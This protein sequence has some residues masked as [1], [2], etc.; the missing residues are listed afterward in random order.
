M[1]PKVN[2]KERICTEC[3]DDP[4]PALLFGKL[5]LWGSSAAF[6]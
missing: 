4:P 3:L 5:A 6:R 2:L 1:H